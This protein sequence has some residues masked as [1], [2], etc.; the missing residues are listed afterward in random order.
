MAAAVPESEVAEKALSLAQ[1]LAA[2]P[3]AIVKLGR[4]ALEAIDGK[5]LA[6]AMPELEN[7][8]SAVSQTPE[9]QEGMAAYQER[10]TPQFARPKRPL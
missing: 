6:W 2:G 8:L 1:D 7:R 3:A 9:A 5:P 4:Q 10:R